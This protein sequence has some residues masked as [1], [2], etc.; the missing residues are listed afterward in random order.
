IARAWCRA[1][2]PD[3]RV[4]DDSAALQPAYRL[5]V[6][7]SQ[8]L[9]RALTNTIA[10]FQTESLTRFLIH[11]CTGYLSGVPSPSLNRLVLTVLRTTLESLGFS[12]ISNR[13]ESNR[14]NSQ[15]M[16]ASAASI[17]DGECAA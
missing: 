8:G 16:A 7:Q 3:A 17:N 4:D 12:P 15:R 9:Q 13:F 10:K 2:S 11:F 6:V 14:L 1:N 5:A